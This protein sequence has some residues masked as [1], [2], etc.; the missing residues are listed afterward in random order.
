MVFETTSLQSVGRA[1]R[2]R[3]HADG[4]ISIGTSVNDGKL[5][6]STGNPTTELNIRAYD[7]ASKMMTIQAD[8]N[9]LRFYS[10]W[11]G[12]TGGEIAWH[13]GQPVSERLRLSASGQFYL[14]VAQ[15]NAQP[16]IRNTYTSTS[17]P[18]GGNDGDMWAVYV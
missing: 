3:I 1:E 9:V 17:N 6:I 10:R 12:G 7:D 16:R 18:S 2:M 8:N 14:S 11:T 5:L 15:D 4:N 13:T